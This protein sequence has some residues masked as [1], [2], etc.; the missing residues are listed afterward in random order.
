MWGR[1]S[2]EGKSEY[3]V[4]KGQ[5]KNGEWLPLKAFQVQYQFKY[6]QERKAF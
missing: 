2:A 6:L 5:G 1:N 3:V 4:V